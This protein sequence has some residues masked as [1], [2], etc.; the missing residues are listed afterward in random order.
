MCSGYSGRAQVELRHAQECSPS[1]QVK[2]AATHVQILKRN[3][4]KKRLSLTYLVARAD[5]CIMSPHCSF[6]ALGTKIYSGTGTRIS[7]RL[8]PSLPREKT[9]LAKIPL[10]SVVVSILDGISQVSQESICINTRIN[11]YP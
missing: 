11:S 6:I 7:L 9:G 4:R 10:V 5:I 3:K 1:A 2:A 8:Q